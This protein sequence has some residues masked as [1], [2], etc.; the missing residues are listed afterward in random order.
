[1]FLGPFCLTMGLV[2]LDDQTMPPTGCNTSGE[3]ITMAAQIV[4]C[5]R[6]IVKSSNKTIQLQKFQCFNLREYLEGQSTTVMLL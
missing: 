4:I 1:M 2:G 6:I 5:V 3:Y